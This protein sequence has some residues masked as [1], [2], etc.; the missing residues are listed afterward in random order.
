M[1]Y[2]KISVSVVAAVLLSSC[3]GFLDDQI[4]QGTMSDS[5]LN[6]PE[7]VDNLVISAYAV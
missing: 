5:Q 6:D 4:P 7:Y 2:F 3:T 1:K